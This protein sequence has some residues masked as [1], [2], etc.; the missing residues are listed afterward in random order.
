MSACSVDTDS[1]SVV[2]R[3]RVA[4]E[5]TRAHRTAGQIADELG[6]STRAVVRYRAMARAQGLLPDP[7]GPGR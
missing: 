7:Q 4:A 1:V 2:R 5:L 3:I 6:V